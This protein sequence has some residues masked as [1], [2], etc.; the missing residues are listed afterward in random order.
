MGKN[1]FK[2]PQK[3]G[4]TPQHGP[5]SQVGNWWGITAEALPVVLFTIDN[6]YMFCSM[7]CLIVIFK[8]QISGSKSLGLLLTLGTVH[9]RPFGGVPRSRI[10]VNAFWTSKRKLLCYAPPNDQSVEAKDIFYSIVKHPWTSSVIGIWMYIDGEPVS[11]SDSKTWE[12][13][14]HLYTEHY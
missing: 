9:R 6:V 5:F 8:A 1:S 4:F 10:M 3:P 11:S 12:I 14:T 2:P 13:R 7:G